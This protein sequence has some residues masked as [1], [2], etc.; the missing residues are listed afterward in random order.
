MKWNK[1]YIQH[2]N[3]FPALC[4]IKSL[5]MSLL[6]V[7]FL[8]VVEKH[9]LCLADVLFNYFIKYLIKKFNYTL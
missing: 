4:V 3:P 1:N 9:F 2:G 7:F 5:R 6:S 8:V